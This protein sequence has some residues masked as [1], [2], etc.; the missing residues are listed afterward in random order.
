MILGY[1]NKILDL[2]SRLYNKTEDFECVVED[3]K[4]LEQESEQLKTKLTNIRNKHALLIGL[5]NELA[6]DLLHDIEALLNGVS[7]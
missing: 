6:N 3:I 7:R 1:E 2:E 5:S 4:A